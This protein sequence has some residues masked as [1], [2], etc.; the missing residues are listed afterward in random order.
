MDF[1]VAGAEVKKKELFF[2]L[3]LKTTAIHT[4]RQNKIFYP[5]TK[6]IIKVQQFYYRKAMRIPVTVV[7][8][9]LQKF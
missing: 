6:M 4:Q 8:I 2:L 5:S 1:V 3:I 9:H 7:L